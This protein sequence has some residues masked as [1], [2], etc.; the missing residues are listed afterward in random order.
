[1]K[2]NLF[3]IG[4]EFY[5]KSGTIMSPLYTTDYKRYDWGFVNVALSNG[6]EVIIKPATKKQMAWAHAEFGKLSLKQKALG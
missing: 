3:Y 6:N 2:I 5:G 1:M 4:D